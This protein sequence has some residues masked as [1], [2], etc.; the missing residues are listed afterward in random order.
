MIIT[1]KKGHTKNTSFDDRRNC[2]LKK[3]IIDRDEEIEIKE[4]YD[5]F[6]FDQLRNRYEF[7]NSD[8]TGF[9]RKRFGDL[10]KGIINEIRL[11]I[12]LL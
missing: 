6:F 10:Q 12:P 7:D 4:V 11:E 8:E 1:I 5:G 2:A 9:S 3:A